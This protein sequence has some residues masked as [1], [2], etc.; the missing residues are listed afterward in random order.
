MYIY[1]YL[2][3]PQH[4]RIPAIHKP[5]KSQH[6]QEHPGQPTV[7]SWKKGFRVQVSGFRV[8]DLF[9]LVFKQAG[10]IQSRSAVGPWVP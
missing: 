10:Q 8:F 4:V 3:I 1:I 5:Q 2:D 7:P 6:V 9:C